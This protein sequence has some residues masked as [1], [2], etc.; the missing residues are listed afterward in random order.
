MEWARLDGN[1]CYEALALIGRAGSALGAGVIGILNRGRLTSDQG[2]LAVI[3]GLGISISKAQVTSARDPAIDGKGC[4]VVVAGR[5]ALEFV[6][7]S[8]LR[9]RPSERVDAGGA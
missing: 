2:I 9:D 8:E 1:G 3:N 4:A 7:G 5:G 6:D